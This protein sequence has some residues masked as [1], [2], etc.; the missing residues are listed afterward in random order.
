MTTEAALCQ[1][2]Q[3]VDMNFLSATPKGIL[4]SIFLE[5]KLLFQNVLFNAGIWG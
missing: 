2:G 3:Y 1:L 5:Y 4:E